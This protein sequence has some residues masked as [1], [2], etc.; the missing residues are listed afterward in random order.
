M[1]LG[2]Y[3]HGLRRFW[4]VVVACTMVGA[5]GAY[6]YHDLTYLDEASAYVAV[7]SPKLAAES[8]GGT[9][10]QVSFGSI[11]ESHTLAEVVANDVGEDPETVYANLSVSSAAS[12]SSGGTGG[13]ASPLIVVSAKDKGLDKAIKL[14]NAAVEEGRKLYIK[15]NG[16]DGSELNA[17]L[18][19]Q[20]ADL[21]AQ[22][23]QAQTARTKYESDNNAVDLPGRLSAQRAKVDQLILQVA[24]LNA[25]QT[26]DYNSSTYARDYSRDYNRYVSLNSK[27]ATEQAEL[28]RLTALLPQ[29]EALDFQVSA[30][31]QK[32]QAF[33]QEEQTILVTQLLPAQDQVKVL[34]PGREQSQLL[35]LLLIYGLGV[36]AGAILGLSA[37][38]LLALIHKR[39][40]TAEEVADTFAAP[41]LVRIPRAAR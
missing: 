13:S 18:A 21:Q 20:Q 11:M 35:F 2:D 32:F 15:I 40:P 27:L 1:Q 28:D 25:D 3:L 23:S 17:G 6:I 16:V 33:N 22:L 19:K 38:Y 14:V 31:Q 34:D 4:Y 41:V 37:V 30:A 10:A 29:W 39:P 8:S 5:L 26:G 36:V 12:L 9:Q 24:N 7:V